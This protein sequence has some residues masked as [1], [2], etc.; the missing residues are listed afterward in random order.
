M[1]E[2]SIVYVEE[3]TTYRIDGGLIYAEERSGGAI[4]YRVMSPHVLL[5]SIKRAQRVLAEWEARKAEA[6][7]FRKRRDHAAS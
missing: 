5:R 3:P 1:P 2:Q 7:P 6:I 4:Y